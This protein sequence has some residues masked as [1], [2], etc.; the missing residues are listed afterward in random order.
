V[1]VN[2]TV[3]DENGFTLATLP[4]TLPGRGHVATETNT[5]FPAGANQRGTIEFRTT[6]PDITGLG[7]RFSAIVPGTSRAFTSFPIQPLP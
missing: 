5:Q 3:R 2:I 7:I 4:I 1:I 6:T